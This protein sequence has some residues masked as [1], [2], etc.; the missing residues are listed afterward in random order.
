[1]STT[2]VKYHIWRGPL[3]GEQRQELLEAVRKHIQPGPRS[4]VP[5]GGHSVIYLVA[6]RPLLRA[7]SLEILAGQTVT[8]IFDGLPV[9]LFNG[10]LR[11]LLRTA[12]VQHQAAGWQKV[13]Y[14]RDISGEDYPL[15]RPLIAQLMRQLARRGQLPAFGQLATARGCVASV[16]RLI[17]E[18]TRAGKT[19]ADF[20]DIVE[21]RIA[22]L[23]ESLPPPPSPQSAEQVYGYERDVARI[24]QCYA[25]A[26]NGGT[27]EN[28]ALQHH[29]G[30]GL[31]AATGKFT[32]SDADYLRAIA[33]LEGSLDG[34]PCQTPLLDGVEWLIVDGFFDLTPVQGEI[35][36]RLIKRVPRVTFNFDDDA[37][38]PAVF[39]A[40]HE[41]IAKIREMMGDGC[42]E[43]VFHERAGS[44]PVTRLPTA[45]GLDV[46]RMG[47]FNP[48]FTPPPDLTAPVFLAVAPDIERELRHIAKTIKRYVYE[49]RRLATDIAIVLRD[50][51]TYGA[52]L[53]R[54]LSDEGIA[55]ALDERLPVTDIPAVRAWLK[56]VVAAAD[57]PRG[58]TTPDR[59]PV[60]RLIDILKSDY[61]TLPGH[62]MSADDIENVVAFVGEQLHLADWLKRA[63]RLAAALQPTEADSASSAADNEETA[64][65]TGEGSDVASAEP[66]VRP[67]AVTSVQ[68][69]EARRSLHELGQILAE[70]PTEGAAG[71]LSAAI[72]QALTRL[73]YEPELEASIRKPI[74]QPRQRLQATLDLRGFQAVRRAAI[75]VAD[76][77]RLA[78]RSLA[79][80]LEEPPTGDSE[81][82]TGMPLAVFLS[83]ILQ[84]LDDLTL[85][86]EPET[87]GAVH[88]LE[89]TTIRGLHFPV[90]FVPGMVEGGFPPRL[91]GD[92][93]YPPAERERLKDDGLIL[94]DISPA[95]MVKEEH[96]FYQVV[97]R[98][99][100]AV[101]L[102]C[103]TV[104]AEDQELVPSSFLAEIQRLVPATAPGGPHHV[105]VAKG[106]DGATF[107][108]ATTRH[109]LLRQTAA[110]D[111]RLRRGQTTAQPG[112]ESA[113]AAQMEGSGRLALSP[114]E[115]LAA[116]QEYIQ[117]QQW[118]PPNLR[119]RQ[120]VEAN[121]YSRLWTPF[122]GQIE[123]HSLQV[124][125]SERFGE[126]HVFSATA[127]NE[128]AACPFRFFAHRVLQLHPKVSTALDLQASERG[129]IL[130]DILRDFYRAGP[131]SHHSTVHETALARL[132]ETADKVFAQYEQRI[133]PLN[134]KIWAIEKRILLTFLEQL[135][136]EELSYDKKATRHIT[137]L[138]FGMKT[139]GAD[140]SSVPQPLE[141]MNSQGQKILL[142]G[143]IDRIDVLKAKS[144]EEEKEKEFFIIYDYKMSKGTSTAEMLK[145]RD[146][147]IAIYLASIEKC[148]PS[149]QPVIGGGY[150][151]I[152][153]TPRCRDGLYR[154]DGE[155][156]L[157]KEQKH[158]FLSEE[159]F[160]E[161]YESILDCM[162]KY[163]G[164]IEKG[165]FQV[166]PSRG[167]EECRFC[168]FKS[169]C[170]Y[171]TYRIQR[172][173][174]TA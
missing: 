19:A 41:T 69:H 174:G 128:Y 73:S 149:L 42:Q 162:W 136:A 141:L 6:S 1:M 79:T 163:K 139:I 96:Y 144:R 32:E 105:L 58:D 61:F 126:Q 10:L 17:G 13:A 35:L 155:E 103:P 27:P 77:E 127:F 53:R 112:S 88:I 117:Q 120:H 135:I 118:L 26:L 160:R 142:R 46:L 83:D 25:T 85:R 5:V 81:P 15:R 111:A 47:L 113:S 40:V 31:T 131:L 4:G 165:C 33:A 29:T 14:R 11:R 110:A 99:T 121:R 37:D 169:V 3:L 67:D 152:T 75:A 168:D 123:D 68:L 34:L 23:Q 114:A 82:S 115:Q 101:H 151:S 104:G 2:T 89:V 161:T 137:E 57:R 167:V 16:T 36:R 132:R 92:W 76:A 164:Q 49:E 50:R 38:N 119:Q 173:H 44:R 147:Q 124:E 18:I 106:Y 43:V 80:T 100:A 150:Y 171:E 94:E 72:E 66:T 62:Q 86:V 108:E 145:G 129:R 156:L 60:S 122:D 170:R 56:L 172:K 78:T 154:S 87:F 24:M 65:E 70:I 140:E 63:E 157:P 7:V 55:Y 138:A 102:S 130:H 48:A 98:A 52:H 12:R 91:P 97:C 107:L 95:T 90:I 134:T 148:F 109:E 8:G 30:P 116:V 84:A 71:D 9:Y 20:T 28:S 45:P 159:Q 54:V 125:L 22:R 39:A 146:V 153:K 166:L 51:D 143:Q 21:N 59:I 64:P 93:L 74:G 133:P 158:L